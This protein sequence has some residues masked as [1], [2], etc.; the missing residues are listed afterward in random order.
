M[1]CFV[2]AW[3]SAA[4]RAAL[5]RLID[6][7]LPACPGAR[8]MQPRNLHLTLAFI[9]E[10]DEASARRAAARC[11][12]VAALDWTLDRVGAFSGARVLWAAGDVTPALAAAAQRARRALDA[13]GI[14]Y[15]RKPFVPHVTLYRD[16]RLRFDSA[17]LEAPLDWRTER[18]ALYAAA[19]DEAGPLYREINGA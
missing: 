2:A 5:A 11:R 6:A 7:L 12:Q 17:A 18:I 10:V 15:D 13:L 9:G 4:T 16:V 14:D 3:P 19:K 8:A 1:R